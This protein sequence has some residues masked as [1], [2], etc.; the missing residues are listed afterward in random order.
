MP[1]WGF[2]STASGW[3]VLTA[4]AASLLA[5]FAAGRF[6]NGALRRCRAL[7]AELAETRAEL[8]DY[9]DQVAGHFTKTSDL[10]RTLTLQYRS[11]YEHL[12][13]GARA[14]CPDRVTELSQGT[15]TDPLQLSAAR[16]TRHDASGARA[17]TASNDPFASEHHSFDSSLDDPLET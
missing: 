8:A 2:T 12:A 4:V 14:L 5:G 11:V 16:E 13:E 3:L 7:E 1:A 15:G 10:L 9:R 6:V 17:Q